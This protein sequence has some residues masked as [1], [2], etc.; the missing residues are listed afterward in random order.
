MPEERTPPRFA[1]IMAGGTGT[2]FWP[3]SRRRKPKQLL[4]IT[5]RH[6]LLQETAARLESLIAPNRILVVTGNEHARAVVQQMPRLPQENVLVEPVGRNTA[7]CI[8]V[9]AEWIH[10]RA[11]ESSMVVLPSDHAIASPAAFRRALGR[12]FAIA[13]GGSAL[14]TLGVRP[15]YAETGYGYVE[16]AA[17]LDRRK[18]RAYRVARFRE[19]PTI[20]VAR[21]FASSGRHFWNAGIFVW[22]T[23]VI[24]AAMRDYLPALTS[25]AARLFPGRARRPRWSL[26]G[27]RRMP[28]VSIDVSVMQPA[29]GARGSDRFVA[30]VEADFG[31][32]DVGSWAA[33]ADLWARDAAANAVRG[34]VILL[35]VTGSTV[36]GSSDRRLVSL[37]GVRDLVVVDTPD[38]LL[39]CPRQRAQDVRRLVMEIQ[40]RGWRQFL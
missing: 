28:A 34:R 12:A 13:E 25:A 24:R 33:V 37:V 10:R 21:R 2:R 19:K 1:V 6:S 32:S 26:R 39:V 38:A 8:A 18:P 7:P 27:Y 14:V 20:A 29:A 31:W 3:L 22:R 15:A 30:V 9:A 35:D 17:A 23:Q 40:R 4:A 36:L 11:P 16:R 5:S